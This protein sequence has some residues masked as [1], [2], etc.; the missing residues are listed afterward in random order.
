MQAQTALCALRR[1]S[2]RLNRR[3]TSIEGK[4]SDSC[5][6]LLRYRE[7]RTRV[8]LAQHV[9]VRARR[10]ERPVEE[11]RIPDDR[12]RCPLDVEHLPHLLYPLGLH[13]DAERLKLWGIRSVHDPR[14]WLGFR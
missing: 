3:Y 8:D 2:R 1:S 7:A 9:A 5:R 12:Q 10:G 6:R 14:S 11:I 13:L 4:A